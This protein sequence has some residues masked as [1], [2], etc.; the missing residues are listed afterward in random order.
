MIEI[1]TRSI[2]RSYCTARTAGGAIPPAGLVFLSIVSV[3]VG[4][5][6]A[7]GLLPALGV[8]GVAF[9]RLGFSAIS[10]WLVWRPKLRG[11]S[12]A[13]YVA[14]A[15]FGVVVASMNSAFYAAL[16]RLP[17][18]IVVTIAFLGPLSV[19]LLGSRR[20]LDA[21]WAVL[22]GLGLLLLTP[23]VG[24]SIDA[25]GVG[26]AMV[27]GACWATYILLGARLNRA[28]RNSTGLAL[29]MLAGAI[30]TA[31]AGVWR[32]GMHLLDPSLL[33]TGFVVAL[34]S[35]VIPYSLELEALRKLAEPVF[36]ML[37]SLEPAVAAATGFVALSE[38]LSLIEMVAICLLIIA[39]VGATCFGPKRQENL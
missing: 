24:T 8:Q 1:L 33:L 28:F 30:V 32:A 27:G 14:A 21:L 25:L 12:R 38:K 10:L 5:A 3:Q 11:H 39:S 2:E 34:L 17:L 15:S 35:S 18:G 23:A 13:N 31:P 29:S 36:G 19:A 7:K 16:E 6:F 20:L 37:L 9:L 26:L 4:A 22:A